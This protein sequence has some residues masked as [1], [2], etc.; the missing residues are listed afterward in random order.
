MPAIKQSADC[1]KQLLVLGMRYVL[2]RIVDAGF[3]KLV[4]LDKS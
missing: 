2:S 3:Y 1:M 4:A